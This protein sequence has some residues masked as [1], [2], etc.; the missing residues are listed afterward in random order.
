MVGPGSE[1]FIDVESVTDIVFDFDDL[2]LVTVTATE[3]K[4]NFQGLSYAV[5]ANIAITFEEVLPVAVQI[6]R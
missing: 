1:G 3:I 2:S 6:I 4:L 5:G